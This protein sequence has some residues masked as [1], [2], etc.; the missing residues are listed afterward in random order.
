MATSAM[1]PVE[2]YRST[3]YS[4]DVDYLDGDILARNVGETPH[5]SAQ[6]YF[7][8]LFLI[9][10]KQWGVRVFP[11]DRVQV[12]ATR[13]RVAD[14]VVVR[15]S[16]PLEKIIRTP[17]LLCIEVLSAEDRMSRPQDR[18]DDYI[19]MGAQSVWVVD[20]QKRRAFFAEG[21]GTLQT[22]GE[23]LTVS[24]TEIRVPVAEIFREMEEMEGLL[25][26]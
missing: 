18:V 17:P 2:V 14:I 15:R 21:S 24:G 11:E 4:P 10:E 7:I 5:S 16:T 22:A 25:G 19:R 12:S 6:K 1:V 23:F 9:N 13:Y 3:S 8:G 26:D 20:P